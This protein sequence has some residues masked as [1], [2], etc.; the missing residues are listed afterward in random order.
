MPVRAEPLLNDRDHLLEPLRLALLK[1]YRR[2]RRPLP[3][4]VD[5]D[6]YKVWISETMLQQTTVKTVLP[7]YKRFLAAFPTVSDLA[8]APVEIV[9]SLWSGL[10]YYNRARNLHAAAQQ[11]VTLG[12]FPSSLAG[13]QGWSVRCC[14]L[15][16]SLTT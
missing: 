12:S 3:W 11:V 9:L 10:G 1:W 5:R 15:R 14:F 13:L 6:P 2:N 16:T 8:A 7:Y 4:R